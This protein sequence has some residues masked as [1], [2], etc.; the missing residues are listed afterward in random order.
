MPRPDSLRLVTNPPSPWR[1]T[2]VDLDG[3]PPPVELKVHRKDS[4]AA[5]G[6]VLRLRQ[7]PGGPT[8]VR[9]DFSASGGAASQWLPKSRLSTMD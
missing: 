3:M 1:R 9:V 6:W 4:P 8:H 2:E 5:W 7:D